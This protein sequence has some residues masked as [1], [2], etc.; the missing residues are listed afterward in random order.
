MRQQGLVGGCARL[1]HARVAALPLGAFACVLQPRECEICWQLVPAVTSRSHCHALLHASQCVAATVAAHRATPHLEQAAS[2]YGLRSQPDWNTA[3]HAWLVCWH[4]GV[5]HVPH[6]AGDWRPAAA[7][8]PVA[9]GPR[10]PAPVLQQVGQA[11]RATVSPSDC[12][13]KLCTRSTSVLEIVQLAGS[14]SLTTP[15]IVQS[16][17][18]EHAAL[19]TFCSSWHQQV[20]AAAGNMCLLPHSLTMY[21]NTRPPKSVQL[22]TIGTPGRAPRPSSCW[23]TTS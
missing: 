23:G 4:A 15:R 2:V 12:S 1:A 11:R 6:R 22:N 21:A 7:G 8:R 14:H 10:L 20:E 18:A 19:L 3:G 9:R 5:R 17:C 13:P 16:T